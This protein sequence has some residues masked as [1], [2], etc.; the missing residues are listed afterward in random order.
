MAAAPNVKLC[1]IDYNI[2]AVN[3]KS[4]ALLSISKGLLAQ[5][6]PLDGIGFESHFIGGQVPKTLA[7]A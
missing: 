1:M 3:N 4:E 6:A 2:E 7:A 5:G